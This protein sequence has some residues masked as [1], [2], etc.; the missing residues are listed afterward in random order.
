MRS[1]RSRQQDSND[2]PSRTH[3]DA[4]GRPTTTTMWLA[5][6]LAVLGA[7]LRRTLA[8][9]TCQ[10]R[11][12]S[13][14]TSEAEQGQGGPGN[15][16]HDLVHGDG[17][18]PPHTIRMVYIEEGASLQTAPDEVRSDSQAIPE[19]KEDTPCDCDSHGQSE[20]VASSGR[21]RADTF[22]ADG[23]VADT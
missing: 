7:S 18:G 12:Y 16:D 1:E 15:E 20:R 21:A 23:K 13:A 10:E 17:D 6:K 19:E 11:Q 5:E 2:Q 22:A 9:V 8:T 14:G 4:L 3:K